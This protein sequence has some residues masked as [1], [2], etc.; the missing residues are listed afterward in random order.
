MSSTEP[1]AVRDLEP[2]DRIIVSG[3][4]LAAVASLEEIGP[5]A[6]EVKLDDGTAHTMLGGTLLRKA[7]A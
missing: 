1:V 6:F 5:H 2:G 7:V 3:A 4:M